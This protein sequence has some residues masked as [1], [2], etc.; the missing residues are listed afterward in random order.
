MS[1]AKVTDEGGGAA[2][3]DEAWEKWNDMIRYSP[4][5]RIRREKILSQIEKLS[6]RTLLDVG[7]GNGEFIVS[8]RKRLPKLAL[9]GADVSP[10]VIGNN[11]KKFEDAKFFELDLNRSSL[12]TRYDVVTCLE[13]IEHC[14]DYRDA[15]GRLAAMTGRYLFVTVP[16]GP[17]YEI[18]RRV[19]HLRHFSPD[20]IGNAVTDAGLEVIRAQAW[21]WP[22]FN[23]YKKLINVNPDK[24]MD[25]FLSSKR[26]TFSQ[27]ALGE[28]VYLSFRISLPIMGQQLFLSARR[29][30]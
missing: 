10:D 5:P 18:D 20:E 25:S 12:D 21:G 3:Y 1:K 14:D 8:A 4:A 23:L 2:F 17:V 9:F 27:K 28:L 30:E 15:I 22:F 16:C 19:G 6:V 7:C 26:Y 13:V 11:R 29:P 24:M